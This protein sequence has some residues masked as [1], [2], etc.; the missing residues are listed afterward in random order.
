MLMGSKMG[1]S[2]PSPRSPRMSSPSPRSPKGCTGNK[3]KQGKNGRCVLPC[4]VNQIRDQDTYRCKSSAGL[5][6]SKLVTRAPRIIHPAVFATSKLVTRAPRVIHP[7]VFSSAGPRVLYPEV[8]SSAGPKVLYPEVFSS[9]E[10]Q[11]KFTRTGTE[12]FSSSALNKRSI[13]KQNK[14]LEKAKH[15]AAKIIG[16]AFRKSQCAKRPYAK[17]KDDSC[18]C[19][20][21]FTFVPESKR[22]E[23][24]GKNGYNGVLTSEGKCEQRGNTGWIKN[25]LL[26]W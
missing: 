5:R 18:K 24:I 23:C 6:K 16:V 19:K 2:S 11:P 15:K 10:P 13:S 20:K 14:D 9:A 12:I 8:F 17:W 7:E 22:C 25:K 3:V 4:K 26:G 21:G 1:G